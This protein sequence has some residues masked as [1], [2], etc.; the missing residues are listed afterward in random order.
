MTYTFKPV[1]LYKRFL[2]DTRGVFSL[3]W[4]ISMTAVTIS[5]GASYDMSQISKAQSIA[6]ITADNMALAASISID[7]DNND[8]Y[9]DGKAYGYHEIGGIKSDFTKSITGTVQYDI[10]DDNDPKNAHLP[11]TDKVRLLARATVTG[12]YNTTF[13]GI[14]GYNSVDFSASSDVAYAA[15]QGTPA[16]IFFVTDNSGSMSSRDDNNVR[17]IDSLKDSMTNF[18]DILDDIRTH[19]KKIFRTALF[20]YSSSLLTYKVVDPDWK[21]L[22]DYEVSQMYASGGTRSTSALTKARTK[23]SLENKIHHATNGEDDPL[24]FLIFMSDGANNGATTQQQC[25]TK[26]VWVAGQSEYWWRRKNNGGY[27]YRTK[28][29]RKNVWRWTHV[30]AKPGHYDQQQVCQSVP[31]NAENESSLAQCTLMKNAGVKIYAIA[32]DVSYYERD[33][34][35][36]FMKACSSG[37]DDYYHY[38][39]SGTDLQAVFDEIGESVVREVVRIKR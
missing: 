19:G 35:E 20:P 29:P 15:K 14:A 10:V 5:I 17:K 18:M 3:P 26:D 39:T 36:K 37:I 2:R 33:M 12:T 25:T 11:E 23:F 28:R 24:K 38:A 16:T 1:A 22:T 13:M 6:Q 8:R 34:A 30:A 21:T 4:A 27:K 32:Y 31:Y 7:M 9:V